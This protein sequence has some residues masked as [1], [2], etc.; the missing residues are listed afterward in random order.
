MN[1]GSAV[2]MPH[3]YEEKMRKRIAARV[4]VENENNLTRDSVTVRV[5][6]TSA[7]V[8]PGCECAVPLSRPRR[9]LSCVCAFACN[10]YLTP[11]RS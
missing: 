10:V 3:Q 8:G 6:A 5:P 9:F 11:S 1:Q 4:A 7:N 2:L